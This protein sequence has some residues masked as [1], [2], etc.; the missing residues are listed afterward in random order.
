MN[1]GNKPEIIFS[2]TDPLGRTVQ[3]KATTWYNHITGGHHKRIELVG[4]ENTVKEVIEDPA[5]ILPNN[6]EDVSDTRQ[7]YVD[8]VTLPHLKRLTYLV[9][10]VDYN[11][12]D[13]SGD[14][15]TVIPKKKIQE[16]VEGGII[17][18]RAKIGKSGRDRV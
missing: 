5:F 7:K 8:L 4:Q 15:V 13:G 6:P 3:L 17:Y 1:I 2:T 12:T 14:V 11:T 18:V 9:V 10:V 16:S